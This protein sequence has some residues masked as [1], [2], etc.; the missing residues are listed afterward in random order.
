M[1]LCQL[2]LILLWVMAFIS[3]K[4][5]QLSSNMFQ[6]QESFV[7]P[8]VSVMPNITD[9]ISSAESPFDLLVDYLNFWA[10]VTGMDILKIDKVSLILFL[11]VFL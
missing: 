10:R 2:V 11:K 5:N 8:L 9:S 6:L 4:I 1:Y 3:E 7:S